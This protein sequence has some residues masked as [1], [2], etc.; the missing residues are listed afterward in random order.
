MRA[1]AVL[2]GVVGLLLTVLALAEGYQGGVVADETGTAGRL[3]PMV[4]AGVLVG[5]FLVVVS[6]VQLLRL[7][8]PRPPG[9]AG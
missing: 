3:S 9:D 7:G 4:V 8:R 6:A 1:G 2:V 5:P